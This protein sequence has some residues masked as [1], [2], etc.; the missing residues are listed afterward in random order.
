MHQRR[1]R[2]TCGCGQKHTHIAVANG[3]VLAAGCEL[4]V[5]RFVREHTA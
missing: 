1:F 4:F 5:R 3:I 2:C